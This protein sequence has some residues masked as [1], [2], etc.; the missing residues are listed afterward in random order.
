MPQRYAAVH[1]IY[2]CGASCRILADISHAKVAFMCMRRARCRMQCPHAWCICF[3]T[4]PLAHNRISQCRRDVVTRPLSRTRATHSTAPTNAS[5]QNLSCR[6]PSP[7]SDSSSFLLIGCG[8][9][10]LAC[11]SRHGCC[12]CL[13]AVDGVKLSDKGDRAEEADENSAASDDRVQEVAQRRRHCG[14]SRQWAGEHRDRCR[15]HACDDLLLGPAR[16]NTARLSGRAPE[17]TRGRRRQPK[18]TVMLAMQVANSCE[19]PSWPHP[20]V[21]T[22]PHASQSTIPSS[23]RAAEVVPD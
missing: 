17:G 6:D 12:C 20:A 11:R 8:A 21:A 7:S 2:Q 19:P 1:T 22:M 23:D 9:G 14:L 18:G 4:S 5:V 10:W 16:E 15:R 13:L 3:I